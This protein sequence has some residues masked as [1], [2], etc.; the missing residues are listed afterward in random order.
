MVRALLRRSRKASGPE[1][2]DVT[3][4]EKNLGMVLRAQHKYAEAESLYRTLVARVERLTPDDPQV[5]ALRHSL[6]LTLVARDRPAEAVLALE[7]ALARLGR[8]DDAPAKRAEI[9]FLLARALWQSDSDRR[10]RARELA[11]GALENY[12]AAPDDHA[13]ELQSVEAWLAEH[14]SAP[15]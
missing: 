13:R 11:Q 1:H 14:S 8:V 10:A 12:T 9:E 6:A 2:P 4:L 3:R 15:R 5:V 7:P